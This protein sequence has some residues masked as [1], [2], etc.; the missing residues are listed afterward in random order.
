MIVDLAKF[1]AIW[2]IV[3]TMFTCVA[4]LTFGELKNFHSLYK[5]SLI[6]FESALGSWNFE[7]YDEKTDEGV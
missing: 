5:V 4:L 2:M 1:M 7:V 3:L 6:Y